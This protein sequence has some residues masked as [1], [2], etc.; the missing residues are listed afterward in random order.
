MIVAGGAG[1]RMRTDI[2]KQFLLLN[3]RPVLMHTIEVFRKYDPDIRI[4]VV[5]PAQQA[6]TWKSLCRKYDFS[7]DHETGF[8]GE[9]RFHSVKN[10]L[11][12]VPDGYLVAIHD[13]VRPLV[14]IETISRCF[15]RAEE[16]GNAIPCVTIPE[17]LR[18]LEDAKSVQVD[19]EKYRLIQTPQVFRSEILKKAYDQDY[20]NEFTDDAGVVESAG[21][22]INLVE[23]NTENIK[24]TWLKDLAIANALL[25][26]QGL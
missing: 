20:R 21:Y 10:N 24:I 9:T 6:E 13:G 12:S 17:T 4:L 3:D 11:R 15:A 23:G 25:N 8:G 1:M 2:P 7:P 22:M 16:A 5:L 26:N 14:S 19:R 18:R